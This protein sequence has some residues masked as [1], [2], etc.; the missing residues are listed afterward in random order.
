M[1]NELR[2]YKINNKYYF[3]DE[4]LEEYRN[5]KNINDIIKFKEF[6][7]LQTIKEK[8]NKKVFELLKVNNGKGD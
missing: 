1:I 2:I 5:I 7:I 3:R 8:D 4:S 6:P